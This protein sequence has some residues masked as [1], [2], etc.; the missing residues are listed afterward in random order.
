MER[1]LVT[2]LSRFPQGRPIT[3]SEGVLFATYATLRSDDRG[4]NVS[5]VRQLVA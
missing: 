4:E 1:L 2:P 5:L 3:L